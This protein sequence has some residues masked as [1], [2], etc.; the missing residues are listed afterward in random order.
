M[1]PLLA[2][3][4]HVF[5]TE[6]LNFTELERRLRASIGRVPRL[7]Q[8]AARQFSGIEEETITIRGLIFDEQ[9]GGRGDYEAIAST[10]ERGEPVVMIGTGVARRGRVFGLVY[11]V[12]VSDTQTHINPL[13][14]GRKLAFDVVVEPYEGRAGAGG[15]F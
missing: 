9:F 1:V 10:L 14:G 8:R 13:G 12:E 4:P 15:L 7:G 2:L 3:G 11:V 6:G 5:E